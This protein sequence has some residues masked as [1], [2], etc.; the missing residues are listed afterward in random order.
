[1]DAAS[2]LSDALRKMDLVNEIGRQ[3]TCL[4]VQWVRLH[5]P[6]AGRGG[7]GGPGY[8]PWSGN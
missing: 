1:M 5:A 8:D 6:S 2:K 4:V 3:G 7:G